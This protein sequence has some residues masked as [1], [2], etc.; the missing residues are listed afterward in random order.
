MAEIPTEID[1]ILRT[2]SR[3]KRRKTRKDGN[4]R[5]MSGNSREETKNEQKL[6]DN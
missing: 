3:R 1:G 6:I 2:T 4:E 5:T